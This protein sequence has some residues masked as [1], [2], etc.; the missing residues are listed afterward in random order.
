MPLRKEHD[1][2]WTNRVIASLK[3]VGVCD[4]VWP[5]LA[6]I[7]DHFDQA[8]IRAQVGGLSNTAC[9]SREIEDSSGATRPS[10][11]TCQV[12]NVIHFSEI[13]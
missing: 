12:V 2:S 3:L 6:C 7:C 10:G 9:S 13:T 1:K 5:L 4:S 8:H 11:T